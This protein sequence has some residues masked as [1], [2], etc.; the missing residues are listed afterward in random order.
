M[1]VM[2]S[3][4]TNDLDRSWRRKNRLGIPLLGIILFASAC[5]TG[6]GT[7]YISSDPTGALA[8]VNGHK[9][10]TTPC[11]IDYPY[12]VDIT[13]AKI[14]YKPKQLRIAPGKKDV[15]VRL[16]LAAPTQD[17]DTQTLPSID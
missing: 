1:A 14:G 5:A 11:A 2:S 8:R 12:T 4:N 9:D 10:C 17:V 6:D 13:V 3:K 16:E 7:R 15:F